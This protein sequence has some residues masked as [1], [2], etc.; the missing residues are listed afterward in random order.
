[1]TVLREIA[2][3]HVPRESTTTHASTN[4]AE[5]VLAPISGCFSYSAPRFLHPL[6][7]GCKHLSPS[8]TVE[9]LP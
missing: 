9:A 2:L 1:M 6:F 4:L 3:E 5:I 7:A 8:S